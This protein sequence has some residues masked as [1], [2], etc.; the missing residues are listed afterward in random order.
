MK[1]SIH[2]SYATEYLDM[3]L[4]LSANKAGIALIKYML[5]SV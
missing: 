3:D 2:I 1:A 4:S 5:L